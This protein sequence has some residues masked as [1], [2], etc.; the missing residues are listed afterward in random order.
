MYLCQE[1]TSSGCNSL[2]KLV[3]VCCRTPR[4]D[5][6]YRSELRQT[7][8]GAALLDGI[9]SS[10][11]N[12]GFTLL[13]MFGYILG[14]FDT[15]LLFCKSSSALVPVLLFLLYMIIMSIILLNLLIAIMGDSFARIKSTE[16][17]QF[18]RARAGAIDDIESMMSKRK[19]RQIE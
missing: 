10:F 15:S 5:E 2:Y 7:E 16:A 9:D 1:V 8:E 6:E 17:M 4:N 3:V 12:L 19:R 14:D 13:T 11:S 18:L